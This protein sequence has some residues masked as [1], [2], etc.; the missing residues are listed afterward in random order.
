MTRLRMWK[1]ATQT[2]V[3]LPKRKTPST[4][5]QKLHKAE[6]NFIANFISIQIQKLANFYFYAE[7]SNS[8]FI[9]YLRTIQGMYKMSLRLRFFTYGTLA[10]HCKI[11]PTALI[12]GLVIHLSFDTSE[13]N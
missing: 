4:P 9:T 2:C 5:L 6:M 13:L 7:L 12:R 11:R 8:P 10:I 1:F 3:C